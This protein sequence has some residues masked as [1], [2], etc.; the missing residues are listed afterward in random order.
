MHNESGAMSTADSRE[1]GA[2]RAAGSSSADRKVFT[3]SLVDRLCRMFWK[4]W[5]DLE[6]LEKTVL[7]SGEDTVKSERV[8]EVLAFRAYGQDRGSVYDRPLA[9]SVIVNMAVAA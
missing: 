2:W 5:N 8:L 4:V 1:A 3:D 7:C 6:D 9:I